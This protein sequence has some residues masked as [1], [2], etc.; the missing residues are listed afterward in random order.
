M[1]KYNIYRNVILKIYSEKKRERERI[2]TNNNK[3]TMERVPSD[4]TF[5]ETEKL[6]PQIRDSFTKRRDEMRDYCMHTR[7]T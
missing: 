2:S 3:A 6:V 1:K 5:K 4:K 7:P